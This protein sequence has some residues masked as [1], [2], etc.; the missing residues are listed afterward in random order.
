MMNPV[1][2][3]PMLESVLAVRVLVTGLESATCNANQALPL[4]TN[5]TICA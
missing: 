2:L 4:I 3:Q 5:L 1:T